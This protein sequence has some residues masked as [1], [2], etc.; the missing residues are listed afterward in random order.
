MEATGTMLD[1]AVALFERGFTEKDVGAAVHNFGSL[2]EALRWLRSS[3]A[4]PAVSVLQQPFRKTPPAKSPPVEAMTSSNRTEAAS[5]RADS[6]GPRMSTQEE[7]CQI[8][9]NDVA[10][11]TA[12][13]LPCRHGFYCDDCLRRHAE[14]RIEAGHVEVPCP[15][16][17]TKVQER[18]LRKLLPAALVERLL[19][20][21]LE[22]AVS[23]SEDLCACPTPD[24]TMRVVVDRDSSGRLHCPLCRKTSC[25][26][27]GI[28]PFH[29]GLTCAEAAAARRL[30]RG[31][32]GDAE[33]QA[34]LFQQWM[35]RTG[36]RQCPQCHAAVS[37]QN[38]MSQETQHS[39]CHKMICSNCSARFCFKC[40]AILTDTYSCGCSSDLHGFIDPKTGKRL[41]HR[42]R[43]ATARAKASPKSKQKGMIAKAKVK[44]KNN[45]K[46]KAKAKASPTRKSNTSV[47]AVSK[48]FAPA[49]AKAKASAK[50][51]SRGM[52]RPSKVGR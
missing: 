27:C 45:P 31:S 1:I 19:L 28:Q 50:V 41:S 39:E 46:A 23:S 52:G 11:G 49:K 38:L 47:K 26:R 44:V 29:R 30:R 32:A 34:R 40:S 8:C 16:C 5:S 25:V 7:T 4:A 17:T 35:K 51:F 3:G 24:C 18:D 33:R 48:A 22:R 13:R 42:G 37:K 14:A 6:P 10:S 9:F 15:E 12:A 20:R 21:S 43:A 36:T 2:E